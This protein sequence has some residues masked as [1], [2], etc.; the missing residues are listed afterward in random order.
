MSWYNPPV[1]VAEVA[2]AVSQ[3]SIGEW[4]RIDREIT[5][6]SA[7]HRPYLAESDARLEYARHVF[8][9]FAKFY[10]TAADRGFGVSVEF[11]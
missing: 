11:Y 8:E 10:Q 3:V 7:R 1:T 4:D 9:Q 5:G 2:A 6:G